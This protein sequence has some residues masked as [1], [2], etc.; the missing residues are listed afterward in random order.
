MCTSSYYFR[1]FRT[2][3]P[4][5]QRKKIFSTCFTFNFRVCITK[6]QYEN[7]HPRRVPTGYRN[8]SHSLSESRARNGPGRQL[9][10]VSLSISTRSCLGASDTSLMVR[11]TFCVLVF[12]VW[13]RKCV[14]C[15][16]VYEI[17]IRSSKFSE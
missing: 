15:E 1:N 9:C 11:I 10:S 4:R 2:H 17:F 13:N 12:V 5:S 16:I 7:R 3:F 14:L 6:C 8:S